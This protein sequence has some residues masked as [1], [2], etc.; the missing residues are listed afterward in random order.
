MPVI[1]S[2]L[3]HIIQTSVELKFSHLA[4]TWKKVTL[5]FAHSRSYLQVY[6]RL[7]QVMSRPTKSSTTKYII[8]AKKGTQTSKTFHQNTNKNTNLLRG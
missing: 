8:L 5:A 2:K 1:Y 6:K 7:N 3:F 4:F